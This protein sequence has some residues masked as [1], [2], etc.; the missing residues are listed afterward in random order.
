MDFIAY[1]KKYSLIENCLDKTCAFQRAC[2]KGRLD[3]AKELVATFNDID[4]HASIDDCSLT[5]YKRE[6]AF[7]LSCFYNHLNV[8]KWLKTT[9]PDINHA[10][11]DHEAFQL[12]TRDD[13]QIKLCKWLI[14]LYNFDQSSDLLNICFKRNN[15]SMAKYIIDYFEITEVKV[16]PEYQIQCDEF[17]NEYNS[18]IYSTK[19]AR[20]L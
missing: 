15:Y 4:V 6:Y 18:T 14:S 12:S 16:K 8:A 20:K 13:K 9:F 7:R 1:R 17:I 11:A 2:E 3:L 10:I 19:S 5:K